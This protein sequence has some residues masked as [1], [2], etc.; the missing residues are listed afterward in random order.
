LHVRA[1]TLFEVYPTLLHALTDRG[2]GDSK[3][4]V[5]N[6]LAEDGSSHRRQRRIPVRGPVF[7]FES[8]LASW[9][10]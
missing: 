7:G 5:K 8:E 4:T 9:S 3:S 2:D 6:K 10:P 1:S